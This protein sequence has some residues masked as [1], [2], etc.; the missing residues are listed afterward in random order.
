MSQDLANEPSESLSVTIS[1][2]SMGGLFTGI[3]LDSAGHDVTIAERST[4]DLRSRGGGILA[5]QSI[6][7]F[8]SRHDIIDPTRITTRASERRFLTVDGDVQTATP[9]SAVFTSWDA[10]YRQLRA[11]FPDDR[12]HTGRT[13]TDLKPTDGT[14]RF[15]DGDRTTADLVVAADGG[16]S[17]AREQLFPDVDTEFADYVAWR[18]VVPEADLSDAVI[19]AFDDRFTFYKGNRTLI[20]AYFIPGEDGSTD[21]SDRRLNW[22]WYDTL[23]G[24][25]RETIFTDTT[26]TSQQFSV[27]PGQLRDP[28]ETRQRERAAE[29]LPPVFTNLVESTTAPFAQAIYDLQTPQMTVD[30]VCL[31]GDAAFVA[32]PHTGAGTSKAASDAVELKAALDRYSS[33]RDALAS[34]NESRTD[35]GARLVARGKEM[36]DER[37]SLVS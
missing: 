37:L 14:V 24:R 13:V 5:Q 15:A 7:Q 17:T 28:V 12:Y 23:S 4:G 31:L 11:A 10:V 21:P 35:Y 34:W 20:L 32:R 30:R 33:L 1:G 18:G 19:D 3:A 22:V 25:E 27:S 6:R 9:D 16:R 36:G 8:L 26:G 2:G 29:I